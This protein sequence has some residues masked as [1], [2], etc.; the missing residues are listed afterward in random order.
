MNKPFTSPTYLLL[1][2]ALVFIFNGIFALL[3]MLTLLLSGQEFL[4]DWRIINVLVGL[5]LLARKRSWYVVAF[6]SLAASAFSHI[7]WLSALDDSP[8]SVTWYLAVG[9]ALIVFQFVILAR[10]DIRAFYFPRLEK[11]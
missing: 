7:Y 2:V 5:G 3:Q 4:L 1:I 9:L 6:L 11:K 10:A 8:A